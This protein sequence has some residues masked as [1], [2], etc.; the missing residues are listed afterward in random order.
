MSTSAIAIDTVIAIV[1]GLI[2]YRHGRSVYAEAMVNGKGLPRGARH[3]YGLLAGFVLLLGFNGWVDNSVELQWALPAWLEVNYSSIALAL[4]QSLPVYLLS[5]GAGAMAV[6]KVRYAALV[7]LLPL[8]VLAITCFSACKQQEE[9]LRKP[10]PNRTTEDG[11][12]LQSTSSTCVPTSAAN[13]ARILGVKTDEAALAERFGT[14]K[15]GTSAGQVIQGMKTVGVRVQKRHQSDLDITQVKSPA[16]LLYEFNIHAVAFIGIKEGKVEIWDPGVGRVL[17][18][19][20]QLKGRWS[21]Y[22]LEFSR[23]S[24]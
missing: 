20:E 12:I 24:E 22:A 19:T 7:L 6:R 16:I 15:E 3:I 8:A 21:G 1:L 14:T 18:T 2:G 9:P 13:I 5:F 10:L 4:L 17:M 11:I 23:A